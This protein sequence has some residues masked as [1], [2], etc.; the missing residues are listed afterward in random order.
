MKKMVAVLLIMVMS[1][2][3]LSGCS[4]AD[5]GQD[6]DSNVEQNAD[7]NQN[8]EQDSQES[9]DT[10]IDTEES[11]KP[12]NV[13]GLGD[14]FDISYY[15]TYNDAYIEVEENGS[16]WALVAFDNQTIKL[17][18]S[19]KYESFEKFYKETKENMETDEYVS[20]FKLYEPYQIQCGNVT[21]NCFKY[22]YTQNDPKITEGVGPIECNKQYFYIELEG[23]SKAIYGATYNYDDVSPFW[24]GYTYEFMEE[25]STTNTTRTVTFDEVV[26][27]I[28]MN[29]EKV[30]K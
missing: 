28:L 19:R 20:N 6:I 24:D 11:L 2:L 10:E 12:E 1:V 3:M 30:E 27:Y 23:Y 17:V 15:I 14:G 16:S 21:V 9:N 7:T 18:Y 22:S 26:S 29:V 13:I 5:N 8:T 25:G 4:G